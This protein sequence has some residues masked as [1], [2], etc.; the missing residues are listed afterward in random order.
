MNRIAI[1]LAALG[2]AAA[3]APAANAATVSFDANGTL[4]VA[5][6]PERDSL[7]LQHS[8]A[9]DG[10][11]VVH[12]GATGTSVTSSSP[13]CE[14]LGTDGVVCSWNPSAG[15]RMDLGEG[16]D[17]GY[18]SS[19]LPA[20]TPFAITGGAGNDTLQ[21]SLDGQP[22]TLDGGPGN[23]T[24]EGG[25]GADTLLGGDGNDKLEGK[26]GPDRLDGGAGDDVLS[27]DGNKDPAADVIDGGPGTDAI[28]SDWSDPG[29][30]SQQQ[31]VSVT[32]AGGNDDGRPGEGDDVHGVERIVSHAAGRL[33]G[34]DA[35]EHLEVF[36][37]IGSSE[38]IGNG[39]NDTLKGADGPDKVDGGAGDDDID[40]GFGDDT[41]VGGPGRDSIA[42]DRR[43]GDCG[44]LWCKYPYGN[45]TIEARD[46][47]VDSITCGFGTDT[48][49]ADAI[50]VVDKDCET[51]TRGSAAGGATK[52]TLGAS[53]VK[54]KLGRA[55]KRGVTVRVTAPGAGR[56][57]AAAKAKGK[58]VA[59]GS[60]TVKK[61][62]STTV[63]LRFGKKARRKLRHARSVKLSVSVRFT[64]KSGAKAS[65]TL[66]VT[67]S[68]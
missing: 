8:Y 37:I 3:A 47:E 25:P 60:R 16:D 23:D 22:T 40:A 67:L 55:L 19:E 1:A 51:V 63:V 15:A 21:S 46:G 17:W 9:E 30:G 59:A 35:P 53:I 24:F 4:V 68:R 66:A 43:G 18:V 54:V 14:A 26:A 13:A 11:I 58:K 65:Q 29:Y 31:P 32:L 34:T 38:L 41:I 52:S 27:G 12:D 36:Q 28:E 2:L 39:G 42:G 48:V 44:P 61:A 64:P 5:G 57:T 7:G 10:R 56:L 49:L 33:V 62:G 50:D 6:G 45:D 20:G